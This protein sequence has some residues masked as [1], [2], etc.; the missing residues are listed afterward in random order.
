MESGEAGYIWIMSAAS[1]RD[2]GCCFT[3]PEAL[4]R[5]P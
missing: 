4:P 5:K 3:V 2:G 1:A